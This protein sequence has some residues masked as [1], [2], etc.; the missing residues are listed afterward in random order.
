MFVV[1]LRLL[2]ALA[3]CAAIA[4]YDRSRSVPEAEQAASYA[5]GPST[6]PRVAADGFVAHLASI[7]AGERG[8][9]EQQPVAGATS[10]VPQAPPAAL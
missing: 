10:A 5:P 3:V 2:G 7:D 9:A 1:L 8:R 6:R 4:Q